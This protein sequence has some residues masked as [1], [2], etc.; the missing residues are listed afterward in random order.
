M[1]CY[2]IRVYAGTAHK[3]V[4]DIISKAKAAVQK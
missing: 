2:I 4:G 3:F 1:T